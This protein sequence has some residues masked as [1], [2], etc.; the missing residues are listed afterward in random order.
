[1]TRQ[2]AYDAKRAAR[3]VNREAFEAAQLAEMARAAAARAA[4]AEAEA[5]AWAGTIRVEGGGEADPA[6]EAAALE[7]RDAAMITHL[8]THK[9]VPLADLAAAFHV[10]VA[11]AVAA[12]RRL[13]GVGRVTG[14]FDDVRAAYL[15]ITSDEARAVAGAIAQAGR[16]SIVDLA[17]RSGEWLDLEGAPKKKEV[18]MDG[19]EVVVLV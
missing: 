2:A 6:A 3:D 19:E 14:V 18:G 11:E 12:V 8:T 16:I 4:E 5:E 15:C 13:D 17:A 1:M 7:A 10:S 9:V